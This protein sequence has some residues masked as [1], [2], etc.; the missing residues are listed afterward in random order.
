LWLT[1]PATA[2]YGLNDRAEYAYLAEANGQIDPSRAGA[3]F[4]NLA[5]PPTP[6]NMEVL[7]RYGSAAHKE[8]LATSLCWL[9]KFA[10]PDA[11]TGNHVDIPMPRI[12]ACKRCGDGDGHVHKRTRT[13]VGFPGAGDPRLQDRDHRDWPQTD[14]EAGQNIASFDVP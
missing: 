2:G 3:V 6:G 1:G 10:L 4:S 11:M 13:M 5:T 8:T 14:P 12:F 7:E 9:G